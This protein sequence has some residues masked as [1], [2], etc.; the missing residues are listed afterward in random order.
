[1]EPLD[2]AIVG[3]GAAGL[4]AAGELRRK[5]LR[6]AVFE[7]RDRPGGRILTCR[8]ER[9]PVP[10][11]LGAEFLHG[12]TPETDRILREAGLAAGDVNGEQWEADHGRV[13]PA[14]DVW[15][16]IDRVLKRIRSDSPDLPFAQFLARQ[17]RGKD[18]DAARRFAQGFNAADLDQLSTLS[19]VPDGERPSEGVRRAGRVIA[20]YDRMTEWMAR[21]L[22]D[23]LHLGTPVTALSWRRGR[24]EVEL[25]PAP[26]AGLPARVAARAAVVTVPVGVLQAP[27]DEPGGL[28]FHPEI[29]RVREAL[30]RL[31][32]GSAVRLAV[33]FKE[34]PWAKPLPDVAKN[35]GRE[36]LTYLHTAD[37]SWNVWWTAYPARVPLA[38]AWSGGPPAAELA[39]LERPALESHALRSLAEQLGVP[40]RRV[41]SA[42]VAAWTHSWDE[43]PYSRGAY[44]Y[45]KVG[46]SEV[47][48]EVARPVEG[49]LF[50]AGE[51]IVTGGGSGTVEAALT[52]GLQ[53]ARKAARALA[54]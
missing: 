4:A 32:T 41:A 37:P 30:G 38:V 51:A 34:L 18:R 8:D 54:R 20:G 22:G 15:E 19:L 29:P 53:A 1:M 40:R 21:G 35:A 12:D 42:V 23:A 17:P 3:A 6:V 33:L 36:R 31:A 49:T 46:G 48:G 2:V 11:E 28:R 26:D 14:P 25:R 52:S 50:F 16:R 5:G 7:A 24:V 10:V 39:R 47:G 9:V 13:R 45:P 27:P 44:S 43:D